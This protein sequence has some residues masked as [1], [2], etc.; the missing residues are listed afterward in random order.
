MVTNHKVGFLSSFSNIFVLLLS[1]LVEQQAIRY[2][3][4]G[5]RKAAQR[6]L[7]RAK[8]KKFPNITSFVDFEKEKNKKYL[9]TYAA[10]FN[11]LPP[12]EKDILIPHYEEDFIILMSPIQRRYFKRAREIFGDGTFKYKPKGFKQIYRLYG[13]F[14]GTHCAP[15]ATILMKGKSKKLYKAAFKK[16]L[17]LIDGDLE[18]LKAH[19]AHF[20]YETGAV[21]AFRKV[22]G[23]QIHKIKVCAFHAKQALI[24][25]IVS[26]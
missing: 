13:L 16:L 8:K 19:T 11:D 1:S 22:F 6:K 2:H 18:D 7:R 9:W 17:E 23:D 4:I 21:K 25:H 15:L 3:S 5:N 26:F 24:R 12:E 14:K 20:D 10:Q